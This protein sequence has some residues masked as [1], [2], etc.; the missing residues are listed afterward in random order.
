MHAQA[1]TFTYRF[2]HSHTGSCIHKHSHA[3]TLIHVQAHIDSHRHTYS[4]TGTHAFTH[5]LTHRLTRRL[6]YTPSRMLR[7]NAEQELGLTEDP[8]MVC[9]CTHLPAGTVWGAPWMLSV[10]PTLRRALPR[11]QILHDLDFCHFPGVIRVQGP[12]L[13]TMPFCSPVPVLWMRT[14]PSRGGAMH[15]GALILSSHPS[16]PHL[17]LAPTPSTLLG[18]GCGVHKLVVME[19]CAVASLGERP[20]E[21]ALRGPRRG[22]PCQAP[23][24][25]SF[26]QLSQPHRRRCS[27]CV[28]QFLAAWRVTAC[29]VLILLLRKGCGQI[30]SQL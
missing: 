23:G 5:K 4:H 29:P 20:R 17:A 1:H 18:G 19:H 7:S 25:T 11:L 6:T 12:R 30:V 8:A 24:A 27:V 21:L 2:T 14:Q 28:P 22:M 15:S 16:P 26:L 10:S 9:T 13:L 3:G